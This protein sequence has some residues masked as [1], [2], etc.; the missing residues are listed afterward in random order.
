MPSA[1]DRRRRPRRDLFGPRGAF[2]ELRML[3][4]HSALD[5]DTPA[6]GCAERVRRPSASC[7]SNR[8]SRLSR[9]VT[10]DRGDR[11]GP[12][13]KVPSPRHCLRDRLR[14]HGHY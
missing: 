1:P 5:R 4:I 7:G 2:A 12:A 6:L 14:R 8:R 13:T 9:S 3:D 11:L 10:G